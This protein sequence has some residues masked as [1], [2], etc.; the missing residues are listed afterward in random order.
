M[1][2]HFVFLSFFS[3]QDSLA[4]RLAQWISF[5]LKI[6]ILLLTAGWDLTVYAA[7]RPGEKFPEFLESFVLS[8]KPNLVKRLYLQCTS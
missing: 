1:T 7:F 5:F 4:Q 3:K 6:K 2:Y 8:V